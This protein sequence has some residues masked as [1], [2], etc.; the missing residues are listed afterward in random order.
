MSKL[1]LA[2]LSLVGATSLVAYGCAN[3]ES[4][5]GTSGSGASDAASTTSS[6]S[7]TGG[8]GGAGGATAATTTSAATTSGTGGSG[9]GGSMGQGGG[10]SGEHL[11]ISELAAAPGPAE[12]VEIWNPTDADVDLTDYYLS[13][14]GTYYTIAQGGLWNPIT[15][16]PGTDFLARFPAG[17]VIAK[18]AV[19]VIA[20]DP[21]F[22]TT[23]NKCP[24]LILALQDFA[25]AGGGTAKAML[26][27][28]GGDV[29]SLPG[30]MISNAREMMVLFTW[31]GNTAN[32]LKD[33]DYLTWGDVWEPGSRAD[34]TGIAGYQAD[35]NPD[36]QK[37]ATIPSPSTS[38]ERCNMG[39]EIDEKVSGGNGITGHDET[40]EDMYW[41]YS[42]QVAPSPG[43]KNACLP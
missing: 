19:L 21:G 1:S 32:P 9:Q 38:I 24:D 39:A 12:F 3:S 10:P 17:L 37:G 43:V 4:D 23:Y 30:T 42:L 26:K 31:D 16:N 20:T 14:N 41:S 11:V 36:N 27:P 22:E 2:V 13:D 25:C 8:A 15:D 34:K 33:A 28:V 40:S 5:L 35:T 6:A 7:G 18:D 29:G